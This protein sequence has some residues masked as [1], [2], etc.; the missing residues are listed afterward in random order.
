MLYTHMGFPGGSGDKE[1]ACNV[2]D[3]LKWASWVAQLVR[4]SPAIQEIPVQ[5]LG[6]EVPLEKG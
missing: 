6:Q 1:S 2:E 3:P 5:F 4:N